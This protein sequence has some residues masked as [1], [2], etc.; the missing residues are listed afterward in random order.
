MENWDSLIATLPEPHL[1][2]AREWGQLKS[3]FGWWPMHKLWQDGDGRVQAAALILERTIPIG[4]FADRLRVLYVPKGPLL[5][6]WEDA[7]LRQQVLGDLEQFARQRRAIFIKIDPDVRLGMGIPAGQYADISDST[8]VQEFPAG[9]TI[10]NELQARGW[11]FSEEQIQFRNTVILDLTPTEAQLLANMKQKTRYNLHLAERKGVSV[12]VADRSELGLLYR[13]YAETSLRDGFVIRDEAYYRAAWEI[14]IQ[15]GLATPLVA[16]VSEGDSPPEV[17]AGLILFHFA[18]RAWYL[19]GMS[20]QAHREKMPNY[21]LQWEAIRR[22]KAAG[23]TTYDLWGA[24]NVF[25]EDDPLLGVFRFKLG[26]GGSVVRTIGAWDFPVRPLAYK[27]YAQVLP[28]LL[29]RMRRRGKAE[30]R[31]VALTGG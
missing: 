21:L 6:N 12:R 26:L 18:G 20:R 11:R 22:A 15:A 28:R 13:M 19:H 23:C 10:A 8:Q 2:Q 24:P 16:E 4:G 31:K 30:T 9:Q 1:L 5:N 25:S 27:L 3:Q 7:S 17:V 29:E 14:F